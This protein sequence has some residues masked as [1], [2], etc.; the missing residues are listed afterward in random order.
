MIAVS[1]PDW[2]DPLTPRRITLLSVKKLVRNPCA[3]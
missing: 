1:C 2:K 3:L